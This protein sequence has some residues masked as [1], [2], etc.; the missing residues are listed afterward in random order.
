MDERVRL[1]AIGRLDDLPAR[2]SRAARDEE[3]TRATRDAP[4]PRALVRLAHR[5]RR[6]VRKIAEDARSGVLDP[7]TIDEETLRAYL[8]DPRRPIPTS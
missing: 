3:L 6:R 2:R 5:D 7:A 1:R 8:Y 4:A